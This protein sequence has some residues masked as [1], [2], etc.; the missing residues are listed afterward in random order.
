MAR[1]FTSTVSKPRVD[2]SATTWHII[3]SEYPPQ[4]GGVSDYTQ[5]VAG[6]LANAGDEVHVWCPSLTGVAD[7][8]VAGVTTDAERVIVHRDFG[9]FS[10]ADLRR[11]GELLDQF[12]APRRLLVQWVPHGYG[13]R[14]MNLRLCSWLRSRA[15]RGDLVELMVHEPYLAFREGSLKQDGVAVVHRLMTAVLLSAAHHVWMSIPAWEARLRPYAFGR[16]LPFAWLPVASNIPVVDDSGGVKVIRDRF[17][18]D[19]APLVGHFGTYE[20]GIVSL[21]LQSAPSLLRA[22]TNCNLLLLGRDSELMR[23][24][25]SGAHPDLAQRVHAVGTLPSADLS[26]HLSAC[27]VMLQPYVDGVSSRRTSVMVALDHGLPV[28]TTQGK[29]TEPLWAE[30]GAV[31]LAPTTDVQTLVS[32]LENLLINKAERLRLREA[33]RALYR[34][35]FALRLTIAALREARS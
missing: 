4:L 26:L 25:L 18:P 24:K 11:V 35:R 13:Y 21:L 23:T 31:K 19:G 10:S 22:N 15:K 9:H 2:A 27:D 7:E 8:S 1:Q 34:E 32:H 12:S 33:S 29:L 28:V 3:T 14:S 20:R 16:K 6:G 30:S 5:L 17:A